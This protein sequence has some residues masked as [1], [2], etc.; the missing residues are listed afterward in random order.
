MVLSKKSNTKNNVGKRSMRKTRKGGKKS[1]MTSNKTGI[2]GTKKGNGGK[3]LFRKVSKKNQKKG[4]DTSIGPG[5]PMY[6][7]IQ[8]AGKY[9]VEYIHKMINDY[10]NSRTTVEK[11]QELAN[12]FNNLRFHD[13]K[14]ENGYDCFHKW[15]TLTIDLKM[16]P[17]IWYDNFGD[18]TCSGAENEWKQLNIENMAVPISNWIPH[19]RAPGTYAKYTLFYKTHDD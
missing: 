5:H 6:L 10:H 15:S 16:S 7:S 8:A 9:T 11:K 12:D 3:K 19:V 18:N 14:R 13:E 4:G 2:K 17:K 1:K